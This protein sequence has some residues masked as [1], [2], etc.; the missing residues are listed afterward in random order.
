M[1]RA[2]ASSGRPA[3][4]LYDALLGA[5]AWNLL[6][7][8]LGFDRAT[9]NPIADN[10]SWLD[11]THALTFANAARHI[12]DER[13][14]LWPRALLQMALFVGRNRGYVDAEQDV[15][16]WSRERPDRLHRG[17]RWPRFTTTASS[18]RSSPAIA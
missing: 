8:D 3:R 9:G 13:P 4:E 6:H 2:L 5:A 18:S 7:F 10:V 12:C 14:E 17:S 1:K 15:S 16:R 11:F